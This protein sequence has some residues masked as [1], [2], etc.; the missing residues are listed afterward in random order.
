MINSLLNLETFSLQALPIKG[1]RC[2]LTRH[3]RNLSFGKQL[4]AYES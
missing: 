1:S 3:V 4:V 2:E